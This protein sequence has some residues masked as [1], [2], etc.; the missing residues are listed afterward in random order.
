VKISRD[1]RPWCF[2]VVVK[3]LHTYFSVFESSI[4]EVRLR[5]VSPM[6]NESVRQSVHYVKQCSELG[7]NNYSNS[8]FRL[9]PG[10]LLPC[11][12]VVLCCVV[13]CCVVTR[14][15]VPSKD[16][17]VPIRFSTAP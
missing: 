11:S 5:L 2:D 10:L 12:C 16:E 1:G 17:S 15:F 14:R 13:L 7:Q 9:C 6:P 4:H 8:G 3:M